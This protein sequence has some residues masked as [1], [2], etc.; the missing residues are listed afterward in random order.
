VVVNSFSAWA[1]ILGCI[2]AEIFGSLPQLITDPG[3]LWDA[4]LRTVMLGMGYDHALIGIGE[5]QAPGA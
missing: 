3:R 2:V 5:D 1:S 4:H